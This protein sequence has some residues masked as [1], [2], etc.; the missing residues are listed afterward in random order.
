LRYATGDPALITAEFG[1]GRSILVTTSADMDWTNLPAKG[2]YVSLMLS[3]VSYLAGSRNVARNVITGQTATEP[4]S[5]VESAQPIRAQAP[6]GSI[7]EPEISASGSGLAASIGP[8]LQH[9]IVTLFIGPHAR[10]VAV[11]VA[12]EESDL[13]T[14]SPDT[15]S[16]HLGFPPRWLDAWSL[17][18]R[19]TQTKAGGRH[20]AELGGILLYAAMLMLLLELWLA[21]RFSSSRGGP[22]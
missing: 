11:N 21:T 12:H 4:L 19:L 15:V 6:D 9:G 7:L 17:E 14:A 10:R 22:R 8:L 20:S 16:T 18:T 13:A 2:D 1:K 3:A 5:A